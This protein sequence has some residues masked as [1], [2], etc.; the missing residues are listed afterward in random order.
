MRRHFIL[1]E[2]HLTL[3]KIRGP[4]FTCSYE[5]PWLRYIGLLFHFSFSAT[6]VPNEASEAWQMPRH[7][8]VATRRIWLILSIGEH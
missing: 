4:T 7:R 6:M 1:A 3:Q 5:F 2:D 8:E